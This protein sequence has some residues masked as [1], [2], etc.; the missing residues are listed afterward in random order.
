M[1]GCQG[2]ASQTF[3]LARE[4]HAT[5]GFLF[6]LEA[7]RDL[8]EDEHETST[9]RRDEHDDEDECGVFTSSKDGSPIA[10]CR[11]TQWHSFPLRPSTDAGG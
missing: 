11:S 5:G 1:A 10:F 8:I 6:L 3:E 2:L 4:K 9:R 7:S